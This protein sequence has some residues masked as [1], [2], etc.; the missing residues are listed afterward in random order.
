MNTDKIELYCQNLSSD[1]ALMLINYLGKIDTWY[2]SAEPL[3]DNQGVADETKIDMVLSHAIG[4]NKLYANVKLIDTN[5]NKTDTEISTPEYLGIKFTLDFKLDP[6]EDHLAVH[7]DSH[8]SEYITHDEWNTFKDELISSLNHHMEVLKFNK[9]QRL[10]PD[11]VDDTVESD[12]VK[13]QEE[14]TTE[15]KEDVKEEID[16][17]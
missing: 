2:A 1:E 13:V 17:V 4:Y 15:T 7:S 12:E 8:D 16:D 14:P 10:N 6:E 11:D 5:I 9:I 3:N